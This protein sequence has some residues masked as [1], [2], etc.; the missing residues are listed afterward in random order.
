[1]NALTQNF[2]SNESSC[3]FANILKQ[4]PLGE[5]QTQD[6]T[7]YTGNTFSE[8]VEMALNQQKVRNSHTQKANKY[9]DQSNQFREESSLFSYADDCDLENNFTEEDVSISKTKTSAFSSNPL[10]INKGSV[11]TQDKESFLSKVG[12]SSP[13][14]KP[15][16][17]DISSEKEEFSFRNA[18][19]N[20]STFSCRF[21]E[22]VVPENDGKR[23]SLFKP[24]SKF[25]RSK[26]SV[27]RRGKKVRKT[28]AISEARSSKSEDVARS[29]IIKGKFRVCNQFGRRNLFLES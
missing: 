12:K 9:L 23:K 22:S 11:K 17:V 13:Q 10:T 1:M 2:V 7:G 25:K 21:G 16:T 4:S 3:F 18:M 20:N 6:R 5:P 15:A 24:Q 26:R 27:S 8:L 19:N 29:P 14:P 28:R